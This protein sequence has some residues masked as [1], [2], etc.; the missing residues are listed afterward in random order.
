M[1]TRVQGLTISAVILAYGIVGAIAQERM[2]PQLDQP[3]MESHPTSQE[4]AG[5]M[6]QGRLMGVA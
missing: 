1:Y 6:G 5:T 2:T 4:G 3:Q